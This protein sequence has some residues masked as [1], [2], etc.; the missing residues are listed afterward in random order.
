MADLLIKN[1]YI[2]NGDNSSQEPQDIL[3]NDGIIAA[4]GKDLPSDAEKVIDGAG[5]FASPGFIDMHVHL[6]DPGQTHKEDIFTGCEAAAAGG[7]TTVAAMPNTAPSVDT[8][9]AV[10]YIV[11]KAADA[12]ARVIPV[13]AIT[14]GLAG[15]ELTDM[16][17][18]VKAGA[19]AF[20][21]DGV[22]VATSALMLEAMKK[23]KALGVPVLAHCEDSSLAAGGKMNEGEIS[24]SLGVKGIP[25]AAEDAGTAREL[26]LAFSSGTRVHI[27]HVSTAE[28]V[29]LI[30]AA[31]AMGADVTAET[32]P[33]YFTLTEEELKKRDADYRMNPPLRKERDKNAIIAGIIDGTIDVIATDHAPHSKE[34]KADFVSAPNGSVGLETSFAASLTALVKTGKITLPKLVSMISAVPAKLL[35]LDCGEIAVGKPADIAVFDIGE[36]WVVNPAR[37]HGKSANT[38]FKGMELTGKVKYTV[39]RGRVVFQD[40]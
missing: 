33:H 4:V 34:E 36:K 2:I 32:C 37:L 22:P 15:K 16:Q 26:A 5:L 23:A 6:R 20:S 21:D 31:K 29:E 24:R 40:I 10:E 30:R 38:P 28:S 13:A 11:K 1:V 14:K 17:A 19:G 27:C 9:E 7:V 12:K 8:A 3:I 25:G 18:L 39:C 35:G